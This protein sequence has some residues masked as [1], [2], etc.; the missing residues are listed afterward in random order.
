MVEM[1]VSGG[2]MRGRVTPHLPTHHPSTPP[3]TIYPYDKISHGERKLGPC[4]SVMGAKRRLQGQAW[5]R[6][7]AVFHVGE[8][9]HDLRVCGGRVRG[10]RVSRRRDERSAISRCFTH[11]LTD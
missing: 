7:G 6:G 10:P 2:H 9:E 3:T 5:P 4:E 1:V 11:W 8:V